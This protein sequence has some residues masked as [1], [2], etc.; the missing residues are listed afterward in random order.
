MTEVTATARKASIYALGMVLTQA[1]SFIML[2][3]YTR[4]LTPAMYGTIEILVLSINVA[5]L[6]ISIGIQQSF[7]RLYFEYSDEDR[8]KEFLATAFL[9]VILLYATASGIGFAFAQRLGEVLLQG[10]PKDTY[11]FHL[12]FLIL[13]VG[14]FNELPLLFIQ[15]QQKAFFS[16]WCLWR[17]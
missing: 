2:P 9:M 1:T 14:A 5:G 15:L 4:F 17:P 13:F 12:A 8:K 16:S 3:I 7:N 6:V 10:T 11:S